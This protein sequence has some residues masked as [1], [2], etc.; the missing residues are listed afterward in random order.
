[1][2]LEVIEIMTRTSNNRFHLLSFDVIP[3]V[4]TLLQLCNY[5]LKN[6]KDFS[7]DSTLFKT[8]KVFSFSLTA[9]F[10]TLHV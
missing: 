1:M 10:F 9:R 8:F 5:I 7:K 3:K 2:I 4:V 6:I